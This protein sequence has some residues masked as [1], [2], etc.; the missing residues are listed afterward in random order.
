MYFLR[1]KYL[2]N[3][4]VIAYFLPCIESI[5]FPKDQC[6][7]ILLKY[8]LIPTNSMFQF[9]HTSFIKLSLQIAC[10]H[11][12]PEKL[13]EGLTRKCARRCVFVCVQH[14]LVFVY[15]GIIKQ[16]ILSLCT[17]SKNLAKF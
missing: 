4:I 6:N 13:K 8:I 2:H 14:T 10:W 11:P 16:S 12:E 5:Y 15:N 3:N 1:K 9:K 7:D 17:S